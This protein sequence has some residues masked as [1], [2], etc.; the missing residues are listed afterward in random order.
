M[1]KAYDFRKRLDTV[2][3]IIEWNKLQNSKQNEIALD[4]DWTICSPSGFDEGSAGWDLR[5]FLGDSFRLELKS[6]TIPVKEKMIL[7]EEMN[8]DR[9]FDFQVASGQVT[10][11]GHTRRGVY[12]LED[13]MKFREAPFL[14][15]SQGRRDPIFTP[16]MVHSGW[17]LDQF[18]NSHLNAIAHAGFDAIMLYVKGVNRTTVGYHDFNDT[19]RRA[20][21]FGL[22]VYFYSYIDS[23]KHPDDPDADEFFEK[24]YGSVFHACENVKGLILVGESCQFPSRDPRVRP[25]TGSRRGDCKNSTDPRP[26]P[27]YFPADDYPRWLNKVKSAVRRYQPEVE[28][29]F[30]TY[31]WGNRPASD[32]LP[33]IDHLPDDIVLEV[34]FEMFQKIQYENHLGMVPDYTITYPGPCETFTSEA[35][36]AHRHNLPLYSITNTGGLTWDCGVVPYIPAPYQWFKR[37][38]TMHEAHAKWNLSGIMDS[39]HYGWFPNPIQECAK[40]NFWT[41]HVE[42]ERILEKLAVRDFGAEA[43][44]EVLKA[45]QYWSDALDAYLP[46]FDDQ[47]GPLRIGPS[48]PFIFHPILYPYAEQ[49]LKI[50]Y[51]DYAYRGNERSIVTEFY[52]PEQIPGSTFIG[53]RI[54]EDIR[55]IIRA[56]EI[57]DRGVNVMN[58]ALTHVP[59]NKRNQARFYAGVGHFF[60]NTLRSLLGIKRWW[61]CNKKLETEYDFAAA[62]R[63]LDELQQI[64]E[65]ERLNVLDTIPLV[66]YDSRLGWEPTMEYVTDR[67]HL[68]WK[69]ERLDVFLQQTL[70]AYRKTIL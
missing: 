29:I 39:H 40:W 3:P 49:Q 45:W 35:E 5:S 30:W 68:E 26:G 22:D 20:A 37:F 24:Q 43:A 56:L 19:I 27:G 53:R 31:N 63:L 21:R 18:P 62:N 23:F 7:L 64:A 1:E 52:Q 55:M 41:P 46:G 59:E 65:A 2:H 47:C 44:P 69:L 6:S 36:A 15:M 16:R 17:G 25:T 48:Y 58:N 51:E 61:L 13:L 38:R 66:E 34:T 33:L 12:Y 57:F 11:R 50:P 14:E 67:K 70:L 42:A 28:I 32:R 9:G 8:G 10:L 60:R 54:Y 4:E